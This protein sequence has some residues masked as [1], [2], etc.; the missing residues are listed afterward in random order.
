MT[1]YY[2]IPALDIQTYTINYD[3]NGGSGAPSSQTYTYATGGT[4]TL[5]STV[6]TRSGY[7]FEGWSTSS[8]DTTA[9]YSAGGSFDTGIQNDT[10]LYAVW[11]VRLSQNVYIYLETG[12]VYARGYFVSDSYYI[13]NTGA[14][15]APSFTVGDAFSFASNGVVA[16]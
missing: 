4:V 15:Y 9:T 11:S 5:S 8:S 7:V 2:T 10:I 14:I 6:P 16:T 13:D 3:A 1:A 12:V